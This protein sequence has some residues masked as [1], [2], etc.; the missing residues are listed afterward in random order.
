[1]GENGGYDGSEGTSEYSDPDQGRK[2]KCNDPNCWKCNCFPHSALVETPRGRTQIGNLSKGQTILSYSS[3]GALVTRI[4]TRKLVHEPAA[5]IRVAFESE[6][7]TLQ[8]TTSHSFLTD[9]GYQSLQKLRPG[10]FITRVIASKIVRSR[11]VSITPTGIME[12]V[13]NL[14]TQGEH[15]FIADGCIAHNFTHLRM[16]R[17]VLHRLFFDSLVF[18][19]DDGLHALHV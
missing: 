18:Q 17:V 16:L 8:C 6:E 10:D 7:A 15:N 11:V 12:P 19:K 13:F 14:Y 9:K 4:I 2:Y 1:M 5:L 3:D